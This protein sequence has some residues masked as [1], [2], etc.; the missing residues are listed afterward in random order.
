MHLF[1]PVVQLSRVAVG[2][3]NPRAAKRCQDLLSAFDTL[4]SHLLTTFTALSTAFALRKKSKDNDASASESKECAHLAFVVGPS[5]GAAKARVM[6][7]IDGL[8]VKMWGMRDNNMSQ[9]HS[10]NHEDSDEDKYEGDE[11]ADVDSDE[12]DEDE[13]EDDEDEGEDEDEDESEDSEGEDDYETSSEE[14]SGS[15]SEHSGL[16]SESPSPPS[17][18]P[19]SPS[20]SLT[21]EEAHKP[22]PLS[23][24]VP[25]PIATPKAPEVFVQSRAEEQAALRSAER[26]LSRTLADAC[27]EDTGGIACE[28]CTLLDFSVKDV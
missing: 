20:H 8:E 26:L 25:R 14:D 6:L 16:R 15:V 10:N 3:S 2:L 22:S 1:S 23:P 7:V 11:E 24:A 17:S 5:V 19:S 12:A 13:D 28:L 9:D 27:A 21:V 4:S 18:S